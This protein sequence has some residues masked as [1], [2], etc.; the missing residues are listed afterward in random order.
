LLE[1]EAEEEERRLRDKGLLIANE[2]IVLNH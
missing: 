1:S 2:F